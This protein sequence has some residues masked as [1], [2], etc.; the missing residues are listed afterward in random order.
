MVQRSDDLAVPQHQTVPLLMGVIEAN[1]TEPETSMKIT[2]V[3]QVPPMFLGDI[4]KGIIAAT[5]INARINI[6]T[7]A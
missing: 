1:G 6:E 4:I 5:P 3:A 2:I 7:I